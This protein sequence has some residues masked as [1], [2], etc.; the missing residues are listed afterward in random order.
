[1]PYFWM[2]SFSNI[3]TFLFI[4]LNFHIDFTPAK[5]YVIV[6]RHNCCL[7]LSSKSIWYMVCHK[8]AICWATVSWGHISTR[9][10]F[11]IYM[12]AQMSGYFTLFM[13]RLNQTESAF[14]TFL[15]VYHC[16]LSQDNKYIELNVHVLI[17]RILLKFEILV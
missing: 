9:V 10:F 5:K 2:A 13:N 17:K 6:A 16:Y 11:V 8:G 1:M 3:T 15:L 14:W 7:W 12:K 4:V